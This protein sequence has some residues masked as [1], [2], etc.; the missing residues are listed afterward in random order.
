M[1]NDVNNNALI[2]MSVGSDGMVSGG[3]STATG[4]KGSNLV[5]TDGK[6]DFPDPLSSQDAVVCVGNVS[7]SSVHS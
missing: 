1:T 2:A 4:G 7:T 3:S 6:P 5:G